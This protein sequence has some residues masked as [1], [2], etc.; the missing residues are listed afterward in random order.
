MEKERVLMDI[1]MSGDKNAIQEEAERPRTCRR[2]R[3]ALK[4]TDILLG[5][6]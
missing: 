4:C 2:A 6:R 5:K 3:R 1:A